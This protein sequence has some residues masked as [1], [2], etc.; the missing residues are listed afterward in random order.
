MAES[1]VIRVEFESSHESLKNSKVESR[2]VTSHHGSRLESNHE[3]KT[4]L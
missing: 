1:R 3:T 2:R 4:R